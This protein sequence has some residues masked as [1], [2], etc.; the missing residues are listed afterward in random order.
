MPVL[1]LES[2]PVNYLAAHRVKGL[3]YAFSAPV[4]PDIS[5][6][7]ITYDA[8]YDSGNG[9]LA[10]SGTGLAPNI[11]DYVVGEQVYLLNSGTFTF[12]GPYTIIGLVTLN[13][14]I[15]VNRPAV[16]SA[17][18]GKLYT[19]AERLE[20]LAATSSGAKFRIWA[21]YPAGHSLETELPML[22]VGEEKVRINNLGFATIN[23]AE[24]VQ[25]RFRI[26]PPVLGGVDKRLMVGYYVEYDNGSGY[27]ATPVRYA[28]NAA[29]DL[30]A[31]VIDDGV[32]ETLFE[33]VFE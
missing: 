4:P 11:G 32:F 30:A 33:P 6:L 2:Q 18:A 10:L 9:T 12:L 24:Y 27:S 15:V 22:K 16:T 21:G 28:L 19:D 20:Y 31:V 17:Q 3:R 13:S 7:G 29:V 14:D 26:E 23:V 5:T 8:F 25:S 1:T